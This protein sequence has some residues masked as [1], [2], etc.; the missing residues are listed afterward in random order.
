MN[1]IGREIRPVRT[2][3][4]RMRRPSIV[5]V[6]MAAWAG[7]AVASVQTS[8]QQTQQQ[9]SQFAPARTTGAEPVQASTASTPDPRAVLDK[10]CITCHNQRLRTAGLALDTFDVTTPSTNAETSERI[11]AKL[12]AGSMPPLGRPRPDAATYR[13]VASRLETDIDRAWA[14]HPNPGRTSAVHRLNRTEYS[15]VIRDLFAIDPRSLD[16]KSLLPG[17]DTADGSFDNIAEVLTISTAHLERYLS[18]ARQ[19]TR[20][21]IGLP[22]AS[23]RLETFPIP[24]H[25]VQDDRQS[26]DL[27]FGSRGGMA[28]KYDFPVDAEYLIKIRLRRQYQD[29]IMGMGWPQQLDVRLDGRLLKR[30]TVGGSAP[31]RPV[32]ASYAGDG[33]PGFAGAPEWEKYMQTGGDAGLEIRVPIS[34]GPRTIGV[35]FV[36]ELWE[37]EGLPQPLQRGRVLTNDQIYMGYASVGA[38]TIGGPYQVAG[39]AKDTPSRRAIFVCQPASERSDSSAAEEYPGQPARERS[40]VGPAGPRKRSEPSGAEGPPRVINDVACASRILARMARLAYRRPV[41]KTDVDT[42]LDFFEQGQR[43]GGSF[44]SG[45]QFALERILV[46]PDFLLRVSREPN[47]PA[48]PYRLGDLEV[49]SRLSFFLW[50]SIPDERLLDLAE[51]AQLTKPVVLEQQVRRMLADPRAKAALV[52]DFAAQ[53]LNLRRV[54]EVV[55]HPELYPTFDDSLLDAFKRETELFVGSTLEED[56]SVLDLLRANYTFVNERLARHYGIPGIYGSR[57]RRVTLSNA[58]QRGGL[59]ANG[60]LLATTSYPDRTSPVLRGKW[61]LNNIFGLPVPPPPPGVDTNLAETKPGEVPPSIRERLAQHRKDPSCASCHSVIDPLGFAL[62]NFDAIGG[63]RTIDESGKRVD[64][65]GTTVSGEKV[66]GLSGL[67]AALLE[68]SDRFP[69]TVT[70]KLLAYALGRRLEYYDHPAVRQI[71]RDAAADDYRWSSLVLGIV[72]SPPFLMR[73]RQAAVN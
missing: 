11:I 70:E 44:D 60:S 50:G 18:V 5:A 40:G 46:D 41:T 72:K 13:A 65:N 26:E 34:A 51:R 31:G 73:A 32:A 61:L 47:Q 24:L 20:L 36:R 59:L 25:V 23:P 45:I 62:E 10:Y 28:I 66:E 6:F 53:W 68:Q 64:A 35:S 30:F 56:R 15:H 48:G 7:A 43:D 29:Y 27:P 69:R 33:E 19:I 12:R 9:D 3:R 1:A 55:V 52:N 67:R 38:V 16:V 21:A 8:A 39:T 54:D 2:W 17:D 57:F 49:A 14:A 63:W 4:A 71:V 22:P 58:D 37:P 42:L